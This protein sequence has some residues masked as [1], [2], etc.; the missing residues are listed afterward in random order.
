MADFDEQRS[1]GLSPVVDEPNS[2]EDTTCKRSTESQTT[3]ALFD[4][5]REKVGL[6]VT[7][8]AARVPRGWSSGAR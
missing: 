5:L 1:A 3:D 7:A 2:M 6:V 4:V 8:G